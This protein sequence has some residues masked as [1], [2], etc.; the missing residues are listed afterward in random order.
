MQDAEYSLR[1]IM[2]VVSKHFETSF[3]IVCD[4]LSN[5]TRNM[6]DTSKYSTE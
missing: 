4:L 6:R 2:L 1:R 3:E 5:A